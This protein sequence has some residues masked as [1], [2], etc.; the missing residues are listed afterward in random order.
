MSPSD[1]PVKPTPPVW[2]PPEWAPRIRQSLIRRL[3]ETDALG[4]YDDEL[5]DEV[6][7]GIGSPLR[8]LH[9]RGGGRP[10]A[11][12]NALPAGRS[13]CTTPARMRSCTA[14]PAAG[15]WPGR[16]ISK[17][18]STSSSAARRR[19]WRSSRNLSTNSRLHKRSPEKMLLIDRLIHGFHYYLQFG[20]TRAAGRQPDRGELP[21]GGGFPRPPDLRRGQHARHTPGTPGVAPDDQPD[22]GYLEG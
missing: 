7:W 11:A 10:R 18:S 16:R 2:A 9:H 4:I 19:C 17:P 12:S 14:Q 22:R 13:C 5:L 3:Y 15:K 1:P 21:R 20:S 6:G 8:E